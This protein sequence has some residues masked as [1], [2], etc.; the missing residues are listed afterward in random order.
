MNRKTLLKS[1]LLLVLTAA[2]MPAFAEKDPAENKSLLWEISGN[3]LQKPSY[4][5]GTIHAICPEDFVLHDIVKLKL[6]AAEQ[7]SLEVDM[8][9]PGFL[10]EIQKGAVLP[11]GGSLKSLYSEADYQTLSA[12]FSSTLG[13]DLQ[14]LDMLK[15]FLL[16]S[17]I[18]LQLTECTPSSYEQTLMKLAQEQGKEV[19]GVETVQD[20]LTAFD[21]IPQE[22][23]AAMLLE[24]IE[25]MEESRVSYRKMVKLYLAQDLDE[26]EKLIKEEYKEEHKLYEEALFTDRN[27][28]WIP[29]IERT[30]KEK[31]TFFAVGAGHLPGPDGV[32]ALLRQR[33]YTVKA[34]VQ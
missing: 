21:K 29:T 33:G 8:D 30:A 14:R 26:L 12:H 19:I 16:N 23:Q 1:L 11:N 20:Q 9:D 27:K 18:L 15:P 13:I 24:A 17:M 4:I 2:F 10:A 31:A 3:G 32:L 25:Q 7:L 5:Y 22:K 34:L 28:K 6:Q